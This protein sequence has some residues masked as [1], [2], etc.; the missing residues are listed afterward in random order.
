[1]SLYDTK[2][3]ST[4]WAIMLLLFA[5]EKLVAH[6]VDH[7]IRS[8]PNVPTPDQDQKLRVSFEKQFRESVFL[9]RSMLFTSFA[10][11]SGAIIFALSSAVVLNTFSV[12]K[13]PEANALLQYGGI[14]VL[15]WATLAKTGSNIR[16]WDGDTL[17]ERVDIWLYRLLYIIGSYALALSV[18]W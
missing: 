16:T 5:P 2:T 7:A 8:Q 18:A 9:I 6:S 13:S 15:L 17:P 11:V 1:M 10:V 3:I 12:S 14:G 4:A